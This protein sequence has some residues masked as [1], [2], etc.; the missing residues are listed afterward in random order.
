MPQASPTRYD[1]DGECY[2]NALMFL[3]KYFDVVMDPINISK[4]IDKKNV[5]TIKLIQDIDLECQ[6]YFNVLSLVNPFNWI[7]FYRFRKYLRIKQTDFPVEL[8]EHSSVCVLMH[9]SFF[10]LYNIAGPWHHYVVYYKDGSEFKCHDE[11]RTKLLDEFVDLKQSQKFHDAWKR[12]ETKL[13][14]WS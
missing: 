6:F 12:S 13:V 2:E 3:C 10:E 11:L 1:A 4:T 7:D 14:I 5:N 8:M 9:F